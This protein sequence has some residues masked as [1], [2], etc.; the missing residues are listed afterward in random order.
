MWWHEHS[1]QYVFNN[2]HLTAVSAVWWHENSKN[3]VVNNRHL[4]VA[5]GNSVREY[6]IEHTLP[7]YAVPD[8]DFYDGTDLGRLLIRNNR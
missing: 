6:M 4:V 1:L 3:L 7:E 2:Q 8:V 5:S